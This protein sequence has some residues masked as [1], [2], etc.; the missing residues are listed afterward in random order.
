MGSPVSPVVTNLYLEFLEQQALASAPL[1]C[2]PTLWKRYVDDILEIVNKEQVDNLTDHLNQSDPTGNIKFTYEKEQEGT[3][4]FL[5][6]LIVRKADGSVKLLVYRKVTHTDQ[7][8]NFESH[9]PIH[10]KLGV[11]HTLLDRMNSIVTEEEDRK[12]EE[13]KIKQALGRCGYPGWTFKQ[14]KEKMVKKQSKANTKKDSKNQ[15]KGLV[16]IPYVEGL[17][18][19][20][21]RIF[22]KHGI[23]TAMKPN[24]TLRKMLVH[25]KDK[26]DPLSTTDCVYEIPC[27]NCK[28]SYVGETGRKFET[29]LN[30]H[31]KETARVS[32]TKT[33]YTRQ[34]R[35]QSAS[36]QSK[37][38]IAD[39]AVQQNHVINWDN[40]KILQTIDDDVDDDSEDDFPSFSSLNR[41]HHNIAEI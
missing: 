15:T 10:H 11:V 19:K 22:R 29:Q 36:E 24:T 26:I 32:K 40:A 28:H 9:H 2:R 6:T 27:A 41:M 37:S 20:A 3:I 25:P 1:D 21:N 35:K 38:A 30:E 4:P 14:V 16:V 18:E 34:T 17:A 5:D 13:E 8:L 31:Q 12:Q 33:N 23:A 39:H 7:Y